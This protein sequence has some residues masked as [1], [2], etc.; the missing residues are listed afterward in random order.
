MSEWMVSDADVAAFWRD[1]AVVL[2]RVLDVASVAAVARG[3]ESVKDNPS[4]LASVCPPSKKQGLFFTDIYAAMINDELKQF[5]YK[6]PAAPIISRILGSQNCWYVLDQVFYKDSGYV[7]PSAWHQ[8]T[9]YFNVQGDNMARFWISCDPAPRSVSL[10]VVRGSHL[11]N[12]IYRPG[13][14]RRSERREDRD[15]SAPN[16]VPSF[17][18][19]LP[20]I[21]DIDAYPGSFDILEWDVEP[22][23]AVIFHP[24]V[25]HGAGGEIHMAGRRRA[26]G[27]LFAGEMAKYARRRGY[28]VPDLGTMRGLDIPD[29]ALLAAYPEAFP[30]VWPR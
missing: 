26:F 21:P 29:G 1:G 25:I 2:R 16:G 12:V 10:R 17:D 15:D 24:S 5:I 14:P 19:S 13:T 30:K 22:G 11:W 27:I 9:P 7:V 18:D 23:D 20:W 3:I 6:S 4:R 8:D 28:T